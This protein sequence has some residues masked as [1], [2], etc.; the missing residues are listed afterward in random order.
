MI[1]GQLAD[2]EVINK[3]FKYLED[4]ITEVS[5]KI[6]TNNSNLSSQIETL[7]TNILNNINSKLRP[8]AQPIIRFNDL[9]YDDEIRLEGATV[10]RITY[11]KLF[12]VYGTTYGEGDGVNTFVLPDCRKRTFWGAVD[13]GYIEAGLPNFY[14]G[15]QHDGWSGYGYYGCV[16]PNV[17]RP[18]TGTGAGGTTSNGFHINAALSNPIFGKSDTVQPASIKMR[19]VTRFE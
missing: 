1:Y 3:N 16:T 14:G 12:E 2:P 11:S 17:G 10:S 13:F 9:I 19:V 8:I 5:S 7:N 18:Y 15:Y 6:Y 4:K